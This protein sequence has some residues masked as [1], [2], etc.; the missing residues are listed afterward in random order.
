MSHCNTI[1]DGNGVEFGSIATQL[2]NLSLDNLSRLMQMRVTWYK[3]SERIDDGNDRLAKLFT[4]HAVG[5]PKSTCSSHA[6]TFCA[7]STT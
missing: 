3:L 5:Y 2:L 6:A 7:D 1:I 4:L